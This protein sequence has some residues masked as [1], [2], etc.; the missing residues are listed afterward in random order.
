VVPKRYYKDIKMQIA[1]D[2]S[3]RV[4]RE[5]EEEEERDYWFNHL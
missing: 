3:E 2:A 4:G 1:K 5:K